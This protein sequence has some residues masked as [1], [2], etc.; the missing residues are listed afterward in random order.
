MAKIKV[1][2]FHICYCCLLSRRSGSVWLPA[3]V[4]GNC[5]M[6]CEYVYKCVYLRLHK[7]NL[8]RKP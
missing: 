6:C 7:S 5:N 1:C 4:T 3:V 8:S 2:R